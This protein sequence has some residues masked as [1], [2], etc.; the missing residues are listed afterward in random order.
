[1]Q[2][3][4]RQ[5]GGPVGPL[6]CEI[7]DSKGAQ[8]LTIGKST[9]TSKTAGMMGQ[10]EHWNTKHASEMRKAFDFFKLLLDSNSEESYHDNR[11]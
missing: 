7:S 3:V 10:M 11:S 1:M 8:R 5:E 4:F 9:G 6:D 2:D